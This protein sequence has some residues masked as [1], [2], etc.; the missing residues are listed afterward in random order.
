M[1]TEAVWGELNVKALK[2]AHLGKKQQ[3]RAGGVEG[4]YTASA[5]LR[6]T[7]EINQI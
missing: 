6:Q 2:R 3:G 5:L 7:N 4:K 1:Q